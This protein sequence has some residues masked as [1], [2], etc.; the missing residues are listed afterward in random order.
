MNGYKGSAVYKRKRKAI[1]ITV[2]C[3]IMV[4][5]LAISYF[6]ITECLVFTSDSWRI[7]LPWKDYSSLEPHSDPD[8]GAEPIINLGESSNQ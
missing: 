7:V 5:L 1:I 3:A 2:L 4:I 8:D 6:F